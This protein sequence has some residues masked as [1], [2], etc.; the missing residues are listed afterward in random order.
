[1][2]DPLAEYHQRLA[3]STSRT[4]SLEI[5]TMGS[6]I[7]GTRHGPALLD[8]KRAPRP[9]ESNALGRCRSCGLPVHGGVAHGN[10]AFCV[11]ALRAEIQ[12]LTDR[13]GADPRRAA[14]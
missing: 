14:D 10:D 8:R 4:A 7:E 3:R 12:R 5:M 11:D 2:G 6:L 9:Q 1:V 13:P